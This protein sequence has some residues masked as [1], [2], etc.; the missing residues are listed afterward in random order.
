[1]LRRAIRRN[2]QLTPSGDFTSLRRLLAP[3][4]DWDLSE[5][6][7]TPT[8]IVGSHVASLFAPAIV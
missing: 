6:A 2:A 5:I 1:M 4:A 3:L 8:T 7:A